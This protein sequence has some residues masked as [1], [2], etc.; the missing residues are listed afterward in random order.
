MLKTVIGRFSEVKS[1]YSKGEITGAD[2]NGEVINVNKVQKA[3][4]EA[5]V[6]MTKFF[7]GEEGLD[8]VFLNL[9]KKWDSLDITTQR[10]IATLAAGSRQQ[11]RFLAI[12]SDYSK[13]MELVNAAN[14]S[15]GASQRQYEK[16]LDSLET[17]LAKL[18]NA[19]NEFAMGLS[20]NEFIKAA[21]DALTGLLTTIDKIIGTISGGSGVIKSALSIL[22]AIGGLKLGKSLLFSVTDKVG[23]GREGGFLQRIF[24]KKPQLQAEGMQAGQAAGQGFKAGFQAAIKGA[25]TGGFKGFFTT[26]IEKTSFSQN[27]LEKTFSSKNWN[28]D[29]SKVNTNSDEVA[30]FIAEDFDKQLANHP[31]LNLENLFEVG[32]SGNIQAY[33]QEL[34]KLGLQLEM[35]GEQ[36]Q[37][38]GVSMRQTR[39]N[40]SAVATAAGVASGALMGIASLLETTGS[41]G[42]KAAGVIRGF[43]I[44]LMGL[45]P[46]IQMVQNAIVAGA[47]SIGAAIS[48]IPIIGWIT[49]II[50]AVVGLVQI[51]K[52][53]APETEAEKLERLQEAQQKLTE[54]VKNTTEAYDNLQSAMSKLE[55]GTK[56]LNGLAK[57]TAEWKRQLLEVNSQVLELVDKY[58]EL[59]FSTDGNG[60]LIIDPNS[61]DEVLSKQY[62]AMVQAQ[63]AQATSQVIVN[64][65]EGSFQQ[66]EL[67]EKILNTSAKHRVLYTI[68]QKAA[69]EERLS[70]PDWNLSADNELIE[71]FALE[72]KEV[73]QLQK[74]INDWRAVM[75][76]NAILAKN[77]GEIMFGSSTEE[78]SDMSYY[79]DVLT[80]VGEDFAE[81]ALQQEQYYKDNVDEMLTLLKEEYGLNITDTSNG[82]RALAQAYAGLTNQTEKE[83]RGK[84]SKE[85]LT[86]MLAGYASAAEKGQ[87]AK[88]IFENL[89]KL[90]KDVAKTVAAVYGGGQNLTREQIAANQKWAKSQSDETFEGLGF[91]SQ[92]QYLQQLEDYDRSFIDSAVELLHGLGNDQWASNTEEQ[93]KSLME[94]QSLQTT[95]AYFDQLTQL[96]A[97]GGKEAVSAFQ[98]SFTDI[99]SKVPESQRQKVM[100]IVTSTDLSDLDGVKLMFEEIEKVAPGTV[101]QLGGMKKAIVE[102]GKATKKVNLQSTLS[103]VKSLLDLADNIEG[104]D[105]SQG[106]SQEELDQIVKAG[107][108]DYS[109]FF[110]TGQEFIPVTNSMEGLAEAVRANTDAILEETMTR[111]KQQIGSGEYVEELF[112][113]AKWGDTPADQKN[114][115]VSGEATAADWQIVRNVLG[116]GGASQEEVMAKY[117]SYMPDYLNLAENRQQVE[118]YG[119]YSAQAE[120]Y[121]KDPQ[122]LLNQGGQYLDERV[123]AAQATGTL[124]ELTK[125]Y[126][127]AEKESGEAVS[128]NSKLMKAHT[129]R[130]SENE[131]KVKELCETIKDT[132]DAFDEGT[133]ALK[134]NRTPADNY[135][136]ALDKIE[137]KG[138]EV[139]GSGFTKDFIKEN[140]ELVSALSEGGEAGE[141]AFIQLQD[142]I[143]QS[144]RN[145]IEKLKDFIGTAKQAK[146]ILDEVD[147]LDAQFALTGTADVSQ[148]INALMRAGYTADE[149]AKKIEALTGTSV[150]YEV[151]M[152]KVRVDT[153]DHDGQLM[154]QW[155][156]IPKAVK[157]VATKNTYSG[158]G[159]SGGSSGGGG[160]GGSSK[161]WQ[162]PYDELYNLTEKIN[163]ALRRREKLEREYDRIL[164]RRGST[165]QELSKNYSAQLASLEKELSLQ[166][167]LQAG[168]ERQ[169][170]KVSS[171]KYTDSEGNVKT[172]AETGATKYGRY[173]KAENRIIIDWNAIDKVTDENLGGAI[174]AYISR[175]EELQS[176]F[177]ET[178]EKIEDIEDSIDEL[179]KDKMQ[180]YLD[181]ES[182]VYDAIVQQRQEIIDNFQSLSDTISESNTSV[183]DS[184][185]ESIDLERQIRDNTKTEEDINDKEA[186]LAYLRRDTSNANAL[187]IKQLEEELTQAREDYT[188]TLV[189]QKLEEL[190]N[191]NDKAQEAR[192]KQ[193]ELMQTQLDWQQK[194]GDFWNKTYELIQGAYGSGGMLDQGS[195][196]V[197]LLKK[198]EGFKGMSKFG[199]INW[200]NEISKGFL[201]AIH[202]YDQWEQYSAENITHTA[203]LSNGTQLFYN[204]ETKKW[205][206]ASGKEYSNVRYNSQTG[207]FDSDETISASG[208]F[209][210][211]IASQIIDAVNAG[212]VGLTKRLEDQRDK[213]IDESGSNKWAKTKGN[214]SNA[215]RDA[216]VSPI[217][218]NADYKDLARKAMSNGQFYSALMY[219]IIRN[220]KIAQ[221]G[222]EFS[223]D[224][225][226]LRTIFSENVKAFKTG[227]LANFTGPAWLDG[228]RSKPELVLNARDTENFLMLKDVLGSL[229]RNSDAIGR[230]N[231]DNYFDIQISVDEIGSDYDVDQLARRIK[232]Q[233]TEDS[234]YRNVNA[235][236]FIR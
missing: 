40:F 32:A 5:G 98:A 231:G 93:A 235:I 185:Q 39:V 101:G 102:L 85:E 92:E 148:L 51:F 138:K 63:S 173:D 188:D 166:K 211:D 66:E 62:D 162:N 139:F 198:T 137:E 18:K 212:D 25:K 123:Q 150:T 3:L 54:E 89:S 13:T 214:I 90:D 43:A 8:Q 57:G 172:F 56:T 151:K 168:R 34:Q 44:V 72:P 203:K 144:A 126:N 122:I 16:T 142:I 216:L 71:S 82:L 28:F 120:A 183:L 171:E 222:S 149:A 187:E 146:M 236:S 175:L 127:E 182:K 41:G 14:N 46:A 52:A 228:S 111:L 49:A 221:Y 55:D 97:R 1:L 219:E 80:G 177:E 145:S 209:A 202:G 155:M 30:R 130:Y 161:N 213:K 61:Y 223:A 23:E 157:A 134:E 96:Y 104:R 20:N 163:E 133:K 136:K 11:S 88:G 206:D 45:I 169:I 178:D 140:A 31:N 119:N 83:V 79:K 17:K 110:F 15:A 141:Q 131:K 33:N 190:R 105:R 229:P 35:T 100:D 207:A 74:A 78:Y 60:Q 124:T 199:Q 21:V 47:A 69:L 154:S 86:D 165:Y 36:A 94:N 116:M 95:Q 194:N 121:R 64:Q 181:F 176:Q 192:E 115:I 197:E 107:A 153:F 68:E 205:T 6:D 114:R 10:Y 112:N 152:Q 180:D 58:P 164:E 195:P 37:K 179:K 225:E 77:Y 24:G 38:M 156:T 210:P 12:I 233:I 174:E 201:S 184:L 234:T 170:N 167:E 73:D 158:S 59:K 191:Q 128:E 204:S 65:Q 76:N 118:E 9:S 99:L 42:E 26:G 125:D 87:D 50:S 208:G 75:E 159:F 132:K 7:V 186:R 103:E 106:V 53:L 27:E 160:G 226:I 200:S 108:A 113:N 48:S 67:I 232:Q 29:F 147:G 189:D 143:A 109:N 217:D 218:P 117:R 2:E 227:G 22:T 230:A 193:I 215:L 220:R 135:Y 81:T 70:N 4:R 196:L 129:L 224:N 91:E 84:Y 19:W